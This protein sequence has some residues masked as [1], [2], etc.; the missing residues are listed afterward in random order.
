[1]IIEGSATLFSAY[2]SQQVFSGTVS[3]AL[4][5]PDVAHGETG[6]KIFASGTLN[7]FN[8]TLSMS[9]KLYADFSHVPRRCRRLLPL[10]HSRPD[11]LLTLAGS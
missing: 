4:S 7:F 1:M 9:A 10:G 8:N 2:L 11:A 5:T 3:F 6:P